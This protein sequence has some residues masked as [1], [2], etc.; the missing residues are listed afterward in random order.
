M[1]RGFYKIKKNMKKI[2]QKD[3]ILYNKVENIYVNLLEIYL[4]HHADIYL[5][6]FP[7]C[8][9]TW[10]RLMIGKYIQE[11]YGLDSAS[12]GEI[13]ELRPL[14]TYNADIPNI[15]VTHDDNP[16]FK[17]PDEIER[18][19][20]KY[21]NK[22]IIFLVRDPRDVVVSLYYQF[23]KRRDLIK[24]MDISDFIR[25]EKGSLKSII[26]FYNIWAE[27]K[28]VPEGFLKIRYE[29]LHR[30]IYEE[31]KFEELKKALRFIGFNNIDSELVEY[32]SNYATFDNMRKMEEEE[33]FESDKERL[34][35]GDKED[36]QSYKTRKGQVGGY[37]DDC[38]EE[39][40]KYLDEIIEKR[41]DD[42]YHY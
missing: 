5:I 2:I 16:Q 21:K 35:P 38:D 24:K 9:R 22:K 14:S 4:H 36:E 15:R 17:R 33:E 1:K 18:N 23:L 37:K 27:N 32:V 3:D 31:N 7:K 12:K 39:D 10:L 25:R 6:S 26:K 41:L 8:G 13:L 28:S 19:K 30:E 20:A 11:Y 29:N 40:L 34:S 42:Y